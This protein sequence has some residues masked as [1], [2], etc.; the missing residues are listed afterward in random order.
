MRSLS[1]LAT[2][3]LGLAVVFWAPTAKAHCPH[4]NHCGG[5]EPP[6]PAALCSI[7]PV[8]GNNIDDPTRFILV[9]NDEAIC[10]QETGLVWEQSPSTDLQPAQAGLISALFLGCYNKI[11]G[12]RKGWRFP[13]VEEL[14][15]LLD[16]VQINPALPVGHPFS[17]VQSG[18]YWAPTYLDHASISKWFGVSFSD[19]SVQSVG[20]SD[21][22][23][24]WCVRGGQG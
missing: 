22:H 17:N 21:Q 18:V 10:D 23:F 3:L 5:G 1:T 8:W 7:Q 14:S 20:N 11:V 2:L 24:V 9:M 4:P 12:G 13:K 6:P 16:P 15:S 19:S